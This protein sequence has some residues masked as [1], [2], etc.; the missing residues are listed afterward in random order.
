MSATMHK[1]NGNPKLEGAI[2]RC[3]KAHPRAVRLAADKVR[4]WGS[5]GNTYTVTLAAPKPGMLLAACDCKAGQ[6]GMVCLHLAAAAVVPGTVAA[7]I[8]SSSLSSPTEA[9]A[10]IPVGA[11]VH[12]CPV[13]DKQF[14][15]DEFLCSEANNWMRCPDCVKARR[16]PSQPGTVL[17]V[18][19]TIAKYA[20]ARRSLARQ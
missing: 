3:R 15:H 20:H 11:H 9:P 5:K 13:C 1:L 10:S 14:P 18:T 16:F 17:P 12:T 2:A 7:P 6:A 4:V 19:V 8:V